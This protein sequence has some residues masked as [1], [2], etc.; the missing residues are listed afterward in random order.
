LEMRGRIGYAVAF[1]DSSFDR[2]VLPLALR[3][4]PGAGADIAILMDD[5]A[6]LGECIH[7]IMKQ[8]A[9]RFG[10]EPLGEQKFNQIVALISPCD[11]GEPTWST[12]IYGRADGLSQ[13]D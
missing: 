13:P 7:R 12:R 9:V 2:E 1:P 6:R 11:D 4:A 5:I 10:K 8:W 3:G